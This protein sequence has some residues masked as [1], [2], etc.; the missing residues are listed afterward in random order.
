MGGIAGRR[1]TLVLAVFRFPHER[2]GT[3]R[4]PR[5]ERAPCCSPGRPADAQALKAVSGSAASPC[6]ELSHTRPGRMD[7]LPVHEPYGAIRRRSWGS[8]L[9]SIAPARECPEQALPPG[10]THLPLSCNARSRQILVGRSAAMRVVSDILQT[11]KA[12]RACGRSRAF[13]TGFWALTSRA[14]RAMH[15][16]ALAG[17]GRDCL[18]LCLSQVF[19]HLR[20]G[21]PT[22]SS[23]LHGPP[24]SRQPLPVPF[25]SWALMEMQ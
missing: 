18:G 13:R 2:A 24:T 10:R 11:L 7:L 25:R 4:W 15:P 12:A 19:G 9:R 22:A 8:S 23:T 21:V 20:M 6:N 3:N 17:R 5:V 16:D 14:S 1:E